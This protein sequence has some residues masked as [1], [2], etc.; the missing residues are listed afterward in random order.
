MT[1]KSKKT[2]ESL[3]KSLEKTT[4]LV[5]SAE[6]LELL[7]E[8]VKKAQK[9][10]S[11]FTQEQ[12]D[13]IFKA[14]ATA[15]DKARIPLAKMAVEETGMGVLE[16]KIMKNHYAAEYI[17]N[18]HKNTK[19]CGIISNDI[20]NGIKVV[21]EPLGILAGIVP[22]TN[23]TSTA[24]FKSLIALKTRNAIIFS[25]HPRAQKATIAAAKVV[26]EAA[27]E[28]GAPAD[29]IGWIDVASIELSSQLMK[30]PS[31]DCIL[32]TGGPGMVKAAYSSGN[33]A[34]GVG[35]GNTSAVIDETADIQMAVS[36][37]LMSKTFDNGMICASEQS[38]VVVES[39]YNEVKKELERRGAYLMDEKEMQKLIDFGFIDPARGTAHPKIVGQSAHTIAELAGFEVP[40]NAKV[41][42]GQRPAVD[43]EDPF[44]REKLSPILAMYKAKDFNEAADM[45][46]TLVSKG[47]AGHT[48]VLYTDE[49]SKDRIDAYGQKMPSCRVL[50]NQPSSQ[51]GIGDLYN[52]RME[53]S[54]TLGCGS[55]G[56]NA[57]SGNVG[58]K[59]LLNY[60]RI[61]ERREN[62]LWFKVPQ[63]V[64]FKR[65]AT[66]LALR[67]LAGCKRAFIVTDR[68]LFN[69]GM[70]N[71]ITNVLDE[72][73]IDHEVFFDVKPDPTLS[74]IEEAFAIMQP[75]E[76]DVIIALGGGSPMDA[77]KILWLKYEQPETNFSDI[78]MRFMD[79]R[80]R[81]C[82]L[83]E[84]G[85]KAKMVAIP[86]T[87]GTG[88]EVTPFSIITDDK[89]GVKYA[90]ADY[91]L[92]PSMAVI[93]PNYVDT[94]PKGLTSASGID[95]LVHAIEAYVSC[96][97]TNFT[98]SNALEATKLV[99]KYLERSYNEGA[100][101]PIAREKMHYAATIAGMAFANSFLGL[102]HSMA[103]KLGAMF[104]VPHGVANALLIRQ[105][106]KYNA[107]DCPK[108]QATFP[109]YKYPC[110]IQRYAQI[111]DELKLGGKNDEEKVELLISAVDKLMKSINLPNSI[112]DF[113][114]TEE[115]FYAKLDEMVEL[116]FDDQ[117]TGA[118]PVYP[119][120]SDMKQ[121]YIDAFEGVVRDYYTA[122]KKSK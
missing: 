110:A 87:S 33:P 83:P 11:T 63:K 32:A 20:E 42:V 100:N 30:H 15:A 50:I 6:Q 92:T 90:I 119:I 3:E 118:N 76:P 112:K 96:M 47:G 23:P 21:A 61:S 95:A 115:D 2:V 102:C 66:D 10:Y 58:V 1:T 40:L 93:D 27:V 72:L 101:D 67:E 78:S 108:K 74:T 111:A 53:P 109:Q 88:S 26:L 24:I 116:A 114:V 71:K 113:G 29:I 104:H 75:F 99:F 39:V 45:A 73:G 97:A 64:Y 59:D 44:S 46:Y 12:V 84:L 69:S 65:G 105:V 22:T 16:D 36:S 49:R 48:S 98:N 38:I 9:I 106:I 77:A 41:L 51:G 19:T 57:V 60:K 28:A 17:Y 103:H 62:M 56:G 81:I 68:F 37:I 31:V 35:P 94:M 14:A 54:L 43:W 117:C 7:I 34:L 89:E 18:K 120:M 122:T 52:F 79:I 85:K 121:I 80:K 91:A 55:W 13:K 70:T 8:R 4:G 25:P 107:S 82:M 5:D 86:T